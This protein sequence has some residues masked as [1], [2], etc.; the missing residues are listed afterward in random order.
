MRYLI[1]CFGVLTGLLSYQV[2]NLKSGCKG[3]ECAERSRS[4]SGV[5]NTSLTNV[6]VAHNQLA[7]T[8]MFVGRDDRYLP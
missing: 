1:L 8:G 5:N 7:Y 6:Y 3:L 4:V 2:S